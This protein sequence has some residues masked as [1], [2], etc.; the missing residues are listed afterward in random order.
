MLIN[1]T[2]VNER[3]SNPPVLSKTA[4]RVFFMQD[5][6]YADPYEISSVSIFKSSANFEPSSILGSDELISSGVSGSILMNF[7]NSSAD[8]EDSSFNTTGYTGAG[9]PNIYRLRTGEYAVILDG[10]N[11]QLARLNL[12]GLTDY[13]FANAVSNV[14]D[15]IDV[16]TVKMV[17]DSEFETVINHFTLTRGNFFT[18]TEPI[19]FRTRARLMNNTITLGSKV[20]VKIATELT[21][22]N[23]N[24]SEDVKNVI[25]DSVVRNPAIEI[26][27]IN[28]EPLN[29]PS[30]VVVSSFADTSSLMTTTAG[31][32]LVF[33]WDTDELKKHPEALLGNFAGIKG[34]YAIQ[35][36]YTVLNERILSP[37]MHLTVE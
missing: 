9:E 30:R 11:D 17:A 1:A 16:W 35:A 12:F 7:S 5:G 13:S 32:T 27:K 6:S 37:L 19:M 8:P 18:I 10:V 23:P 21:I 33:T 26:V 2:P 15:F 14:G 28:E 25:K 4:L 20:D 34:I 29:V 24:L 22:E 3:H 31:D 36:R